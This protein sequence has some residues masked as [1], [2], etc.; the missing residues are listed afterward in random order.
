MRLLLHLPL[1]LCIILNQHALSQSYRVE[2][3][4]SNLQTAEN[5]RKGI[6]NHSFD[7]KC[8]SYAEFD[9]FNING[10]KLNDRFL[11]PLN[12]IETEHDYYASRIITNKDTHA[13]KINMH[14]EVPR[15]V[16]TAWDH[17][18]CQLHDYH[19]SY[20]YTI[21]PENTSCYKLY[22]QMAPNGK[23]ILENGNFEI[24]MI[25]LFDKIQVSNA[26]NLM[27]F[28]QQDAVKV[29]T[30]A[31]FKAREYHWQY[32]YNLATWYDFPKAVNYRPTLSVE[33]STFMSFDQFLQLVEKSQNFYI[34]LIPYCSKATIQY[35]VLKPIIVAPHITKVE[36]T[37]PSCFQ[38]ANGYIK[39]K[40]DRPLYADETISLDIQGSN[41]TNQVFN[42]TQ[43][44]K[45]T[46]YTWLAICV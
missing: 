33:P 42:I 6:Y 13:L 25:P 27:P 38:S 30:N 41:Y 28:D 39:I 1:L 8:N 14:I 26:D 23:H 40:F 4:L 19:A 21:N 17:K 16:W 29:R 18:G 3:R 43:L 31:G 5:D 7:A 9:L 10:T 46:A 2:L 44:D 11:M 35:L 15:N 24:T 32:S 45:D 36:A 12:K 37:P 22:E 34:R 20:S